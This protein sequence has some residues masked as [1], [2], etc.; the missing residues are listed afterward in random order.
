MFSETIPGTALQFDLDLSKIMTYTD[1]IIV[2]G[3][4]DVK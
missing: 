2:L 3:S 1:E 4:V